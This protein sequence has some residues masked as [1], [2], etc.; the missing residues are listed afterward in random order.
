MV[1]RRC[2]SGEVV[3][4]QGNKK[5]M[6]DEHRSGKETNLKNREVTDRG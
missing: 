3:V 1:G 4:S 2:G 5:F 6:E